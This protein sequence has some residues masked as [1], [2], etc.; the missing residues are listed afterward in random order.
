MKK[1]KKLMIAMLLLALTITATPVSS[2]QASVKLNATKKTLNVG[3]TITLKV[4]GTSKKAKWTSSNK[5]IA[6]VTQKGKVTAKNAGT[7]TI[8]AKVSGRKLKCKII[9][10]QNFYKIGQTWT[11]PGQWSITINSVTETSYR[12]EYADTNPEAVYMI[13]YTYENLGYIDQNGIMNGLFLDFEMAQIVD[14]NGYTGYSYPGDITYYSQEILVG[15]KCHAQSCIGVDHR[16]NFK[17]YYNTYD[18]NGVSRK[19]AF[20]INLY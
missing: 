13:D 4:K 14:S 18:G 20:E 10:N 11:V 12:N 7:A 5:N 16:G 1:I 19:A 3:Q 2:T 6:S 15:A 8:T 17:L 9:V